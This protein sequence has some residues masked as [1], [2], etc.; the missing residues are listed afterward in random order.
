MNIILEILAGFVLVGAIL[1]ISLRKKNA[2]AKPDNSPQARL[3]RAV[4]AWARVLKSSRGEAGLAGMVRVSLELEV[5]LPGTPAYTTDTVWLVEQEA[6]EAVEVGQ[7]VSL[8]VD[9]LGVHHI[10][11]NGPWA[12]LAGKR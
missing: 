2:A 1:W 11:P 7:E 9:P 6:L 12:K 8:K 3:D 10:F 4:W 5:H